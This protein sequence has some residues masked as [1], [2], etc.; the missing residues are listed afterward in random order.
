MCKWQSK[1]R[2]ERQGRERDA[3]G[4]G[5]R[6]AAGVEGWVEEGNRGS[7][8]GQLHPDVQQ[9]RAHA[10]WVWHREGPQASPILGVCHPTSFDRRHYWYSSCLPGG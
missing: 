2:R 7:G 1:C 3:R 8:S 5:T 4:K 9:T 10:Q 6:C